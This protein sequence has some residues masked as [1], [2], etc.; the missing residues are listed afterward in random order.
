MAVKREKMPIAKSAINTSHGKSSYVVVRS[1]IKA[2]PL[3]PNLALDPINPVVVDLNNPALTFT[4]V[5]VTNDAKHAVLK[6][7]AVNPPGGSVTPSDGILSITMLDLTL[8]AIPVILPVTETPVDYIDD[9]A[10]F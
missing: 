10:G 1:P 6:L 9:P 3:P 5:L 8:P 7:V 4:P 2:F